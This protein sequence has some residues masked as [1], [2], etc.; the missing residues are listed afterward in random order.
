[1][2]KRTLGIKVLIALVWVSLC[3]SANAQVLFEDNFDTQADW[4]P[5]CLNCNRNGGGYYNGGDA[6][7]TPVGWDWWRNDEFWSP[8]DFTDRGYGAG[9]ASSKPTIQISSFNHYGTTGKALTVYNES[10]NGDGSDGFGADGILAKS[11]GKDF[12]ELY[13]NVKIKY[14]PG[15]QLHWTVGGNGVT[16]KLVRFGHN[17]DPIRPFG[18]GTSFQNAPMYFF[19]NYMDEYGLTQAHAFRFA[20]ANLYYLPGQKTSAKYVGS[21]GFAQSIGD[22]NWHQLSFYVKMNSAPGVADGVTTFWYDGVLQT[23][24]TNIPF[25]KAAPMV[26]W[27]TVYLG[28]NCFNSYAPISDKA[29]QWYAFDDFVISTTPIPFTYKVGGPTPVELNAA[30]K[31]AK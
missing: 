21:P 8:Y 18:F 4:A 9:T 22:G 30:P 11:L 19:D 27:N 7:G 31:A 3:S 12:Q 13:V 25:V 29:E 23:S 14:Q 16:Q 6:S 10:N 20:P 26:G 28:G 17:G 1:M 15:F 2:G 24:T 5:K